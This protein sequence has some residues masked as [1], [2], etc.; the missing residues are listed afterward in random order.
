MGSL[1]RGA[2]G[3]NG[4]GNTKVGHGCGGELRNRSSAASGLLDDD[5]HEQWLAGYLDLGE[6]GHLKTHD[7]NGPLLPRHLA[8]DDAGLNPYTINPAVDGICLVSLIQ[9][10]SCLPL[11]TEPT[12][13]DS[14]YRCGTKGLLHLSPCCIYDISILTAP[15]TT[16]NDNQDDD[17][18]FKSH[19]DGNA[20]DKEDEKDDE[21]DDEKGNE[22]G[23]EKDRGERQLE[24]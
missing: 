11:P 15:T 1:R 5:K 16:N 20:K 3:P 10:R 19:G 21:K 9:S 14:R 24:I 17:I 13:S 6:G 2:T 12:L 22:K 8:R 23:N 7:D 18:I 4:R